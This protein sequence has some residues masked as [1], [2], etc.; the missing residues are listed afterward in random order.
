VA[1]Q[2][3]NVLNA[4]LDLVLIRKIGAPGQPALAIGA[5]VDDGIATGAT[6]RAAIEGLWQ[7]GVVRLIVA[8]PVA[9]RDTADA[10]RSEVDEFV[11][12]FAPKFFDAVGSF[13]EDC[14]QTPDEAVIAF[15]DHAMKRQ[16]ADTPC[17]DQ[18][19]EYEKA[20]FFS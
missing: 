4:P 6:I 15:L 11:C 12:L 7:A 18:A 16:A 5:I 10:L 2:V 9:P 8:V 14:S 13:Y 19:M 3:G 17:M 20:A 1:F